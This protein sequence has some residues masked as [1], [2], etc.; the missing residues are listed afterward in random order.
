MKR[1]LVPLFLVA[2]ALA[3]DLAAAQNRA[4]AQGRPSTTRMTC[5]A[6]GALIQS[7]GS[8][9]LDIGGGDFD[10][11]VRDASF[12]PHGQILRPAFTPTID[13]RQ[14]MIGYRCY[15]EERPPP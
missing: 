11:F 4:P 6:A 12:C 1:L 10:L 7:K 3:P 9:V 13:Q 5:A 8:A 15:E 2:G 14:C